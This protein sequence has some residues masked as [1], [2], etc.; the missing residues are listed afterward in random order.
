MDARHSTI[1]T[2]RAASGSSHNLA[3][4]TL[5]GEARAAVGLGTA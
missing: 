5:A 2:L 1:A 3:R 4:G